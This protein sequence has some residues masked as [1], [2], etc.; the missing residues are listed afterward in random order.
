MAQLSKSAILEAPLTTEQVK[1]EQ[2]DGEVTIHEMPVGKRQELLA[3]LLN[4][5]GTT[6]AVTADIELLLFIAGMHDP[7]FSEDEAAELQNVSGV[8][9]SEVVQAI[10]KLN[11][12]SGDA[13]EDARGES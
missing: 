5:D 11:G 6:K 2:W 9:I 4:D 8:A 12:F 3:H 13:V 7:E 10:M 1:V